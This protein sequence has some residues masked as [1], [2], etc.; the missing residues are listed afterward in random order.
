MK[1]SKKLIAAACA[2]AAMLMSGTALA[3]DSHTITVNATVN[4]T[5]KFNTGTSTV[6]M[7]LDPTASTTVTGNAAVLYRCTKGT[8]PAFALSSGS[9]S[10]ATGGNLQNGTETIPYTFSSVS[11]GAGTGLGAGQDKT[12]S[13]TV[14]VNQTNA[15][16]VTPNTYTDTIAITL[17]P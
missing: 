2:T 4:G 12:L 5:C 14:S 10:S 6:N 11:G 17:T 9:T 1:S 15:A 7:T 16:G 8:S 3:G 13:V